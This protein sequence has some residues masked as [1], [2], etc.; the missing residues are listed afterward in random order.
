MI[1]HSFFLVFLRYYREA[2]SSVM[3]LRKRCIRVLKKAA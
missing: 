2:S 1:S 3:G